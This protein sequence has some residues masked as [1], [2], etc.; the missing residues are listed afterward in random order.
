LRFIWATI[1]NRSDMK[2]LNILVISNFYPPHY[3]G[4]YELECQWVVEALRK[5]GHEV[6]VLTSTYGLDYPQN[7]EKV[8]RWLKA[9]LNLKHNGFIVRKINYIKKEI[10]NQRAFKRIITLFRPDVVYIWNLACVSVSLAFMAQRIKLHVYY[11]IADYWLSLWKS[12]ERHPSWNHLLVKGIMHAFG[13][14]IPGEYMDLSHVQFPS[15]YLKEAALRSGLNVTAAEVIHWG[16][17]INSYSYKKVSGNPKR[18]LYI[19]QIVQHKGVHTAIIALK[20]ITQR[21]GYESTTLNIIG[22]TIIPEY[23]TYVKNLVSSLGLE[24]NIHFTGFIAHEKLAPIYQNHDILIF[25]SIWDEPLGITILE[26]MAS[27]LAVVSTATGGS[28][29]ILKEEVNA[30]VFPKDD[31]AACAKQILRFLDNNELFESIRQNGR[32]TV[33]E[34]FNINNTIDKIEN[35]L[36]RVDVNKNI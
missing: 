21:H 7:D 12:A 17:D 9:D 32:H 19:G 34:S 3:I 30:L 11:S 26:A 22:G 15:K 5:S 23:L 14:L 2:K 31:A 27:G 4:G 35:S 28:C 18:L 6:K 36:K 33:E 8:Y 1:K 29:E 25:P 13:L 20:E 16:V 10:N 24:K